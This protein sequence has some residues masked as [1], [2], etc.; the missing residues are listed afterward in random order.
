[1][2]WRPVRVGLYRQPRSA[3]SAVSFPFTRERATCGAAR[4][5]SVSAAQQR[6]ATTQTP[7][8]AKGRWRGRGASRSGSG[9]HACSVQATSRAQS[10]AQRGII[11]FA[12]A[13]VRILP[14]RHIE[15]PAAMLFTL[16]PPQCQA[17][18]L[19]QLHVG[20]AAARTRTVSAAP[21]W[22]NRQEFPGNARGF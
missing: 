11:F 8:R 17:K 13:E 12:A 10:G 5:R 4:P 22:P 7:R 6:A 20:N 14:A 2:K 1:M 15:Q 9:H 16:A 18:S 19:P 3:V 21:F